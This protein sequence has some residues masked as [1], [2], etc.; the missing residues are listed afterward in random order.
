MPWTDLTE[1]C[2]LPLAGTLRPTSLPPAMCTYLLFLLVRLF[3]FT[4]VL[5]SAAFLCL[6][7]LFVLL[8]LSYQSAFESFPL[9]CCLWSFVSMCANQTKSKEQTMI[10]KI[11]FPA[12]LARYCA[13]EVLK[14]SRVNILVAPRTAIH[15]LRSG[16]MCSPGQ[17][18]LL[19]LLLVDLL[20]AK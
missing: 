15:G 5:D 12:I 10:L 19:S 1:T 20:P 14:W 4:F 6:L 13:K 7:S 16:G 8:Y 11:P 3:S 9:L 17:H 2:I 18:P